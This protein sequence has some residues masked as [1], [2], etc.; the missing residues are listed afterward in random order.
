VLSIVIV[1]E[2]TSDRWWRNNSLFLQYLP[3]QNKQTSIIET[4]SEIQ[5]LRVDKPNKHV[6]VDQIKS[7]IGQQVGKLWCVYD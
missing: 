3:Q 7:K 5:A 4:D 6:H 1:V 2:N